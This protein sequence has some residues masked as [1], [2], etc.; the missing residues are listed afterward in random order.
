MNASLKL[1]AAAGLYGLWAALVFTGHADPAAL[2]TGVVAGLSG[3]GVHAAV[4]P[5][6]TA[7]SAAQPAAT[8]AQPEQP[9]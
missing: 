1:I 6:R 4:T 8:A 3:L 9:Q 7:A 5:F 2:V